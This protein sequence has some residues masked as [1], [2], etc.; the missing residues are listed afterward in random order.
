MAFTFKQLRYFLAVVD[1]GKVSDAAISVNI[2]ASSVTEAVKEL[3]HFLGQKLFTRSR[4]GLDLTPEG[5]H[6]LSYAKRIL[7]DISAAKECLNSNQQLIDGTIKLG[8]TN[9]VSAYFLSPLI[10]RFHRMF[11]KATIEFEEHPRTILQEKVSNGKLDI[12]ILLVSNIRS[13]KNI[14]VIPLLSSQRRLWVAANHPL[15]RK[16]IVALEDISQEPYIQLD[17]DESAATTNSYWHKYDLNP[18][19]IF[20][21]AML[22]SVRNLVATGTGVTILSDMVYRPWSIDG[23]RIETIEVHEKIPSMDT[24][25]MWSSKH[26]SNKLLKEFIS[27]C[28]MQYLSISG[29]L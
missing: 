23:D 26:P 27:F 24:G 29:T 2:S 16:T 13:R 5:Y 25:L 7:T 1:T 17:S 19:V 28:R 12:A 20:K 22:E 8:V 3:E 6:F 21:T 15:L 18:K 9:T 10:H 14:N 4:I 11:P